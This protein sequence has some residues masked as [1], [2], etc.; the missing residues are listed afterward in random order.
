MTFIHLLKVTNVSSNIP[1]K[2][3]QSTNLQ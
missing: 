3:I 2:V 1:E